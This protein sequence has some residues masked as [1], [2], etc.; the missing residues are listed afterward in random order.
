MTKQKPFSF[1]LPIDGMNITDE[2]LDNHLAIIEVY[3]C[4]DGN[5]AHNLPIDLET[6]KDAQD[7]LKNKPLVAGFD[8]SDFE[9]HEI[10]E[11]LIGYFPESTNIRYVKKNDKTYMVA[12]AIMPKLYAKWA[13]DIFNNKNDKSVSMEI[14]VLDY[15]EK[16]LFTKINKFIFNAVTVLGENHL[17]ACEGSKASI[18]KFSKESAEK[19]YEKHFTSQSIK[20]KF[21]EGKLIGGLQMEKTD[22]IPVESDET[23]Y[24]EGSI[25]INNKKDSAINGGSWSNPGKKLYEPI[26]EASNKKALVDEAYLIVESGYEDAPSEKLK[27]PHHDVRGPELVLNV[28]GVE[29]AFQRASQE[30]IVNGKVKSHLLRHYHE[31]GLSTENFENIEEG[32]KNMPEEKLEDKTK[33]EEIEKDNGKEALKKQK[34]DEK[35]DRDDAKEEA[36]KKEEDERSEI[37]DYKEKEKGQEMEAPEESKE[38][39]CSVEKLE[40]LMKENAELKDKLAKYEEA[41]KSREVECVLAQVMELMSKE[42]I[43]ELRVEAKQYSLDNINVFEN[44]VKACAF[45]KVKGNEKNVSFTKMAITNSGEQH[46]NGLW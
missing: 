5:N 1:S 41:D 44:K 8:G 29:A 22:K 17:P 23:T 14:E 25:R 10:D 38:V 30:G 21:V 15:E 24:M 33:R 26:L 36:K 27:Y 4:H 9:G 34:E 42:E 39:E 2:V 35:S 19:I 12:D 31:L 18:I 37:D 6:L 43:D 3:V 16:P 20:N 46:L 11:V 45:E 13:Y 7:T 40:C 32:G 28:K